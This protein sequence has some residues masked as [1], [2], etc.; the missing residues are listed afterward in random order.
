MKVLECPLKSCIVG[1]GGQEL[2]LPA[3]SC[4]F[5]TEKTKWDT[6][7]VTAAPTF[8]HLTDYLEEPVNKLSDV[9]TVLLNCEVQSTTLSIRWSMTAGV[10]H[11][12]QI[13]Q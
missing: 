3:T 11:R 4:S 2:H 6:C 10:R 9:Q 7:A 12:K 5:V 13:G 8:N 1:C